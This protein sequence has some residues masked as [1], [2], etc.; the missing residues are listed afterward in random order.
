MIVDG[1]IEAR[2]VLPPE[3]AVPHEPFFRELK[4]RG[5]SIRRRTRRL[6]GRRMKPV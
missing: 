1:A 4:R 2:G 5:M 6:D 3:Q